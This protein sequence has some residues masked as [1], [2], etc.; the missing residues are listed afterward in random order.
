MNDAISTIAL[1]V[2]TAPGLAHLKELR[3]AFA[4]LRADINEF[5]ALRSN[6]QALTGDS[7]KV[8]NE[9]ATLSAALKEAQGEI[10]QMQVQMQ[11]MAKANVSAAEASSK[12]VVKAV[13]DQNRG[14]IESEKAAA[15]E[16]QKLAKETT[17][18]VED[19]ARKR[20]TMSQS[21]KVG[22]VTYGFR[23]AVPED[24]AQTQIINNMLAAQRQYM[25]SREGIERQ[26]EATHR[27]IMFDS[28]MRDQT[29]LDDMLAAR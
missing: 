23:Q 20:Y 18:V 16:T 12:A 26:A 22:S 9:L 3:A 19:E 24:K 13:Q 10:A 8:K 7:G 14:V 28:A 27:Q 21:A 17:K 15:A 29:V 2:D 5:N 6:P 4:G 11:S 25:A 1:G